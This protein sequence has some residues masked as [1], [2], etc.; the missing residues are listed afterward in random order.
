VV[1]IT[2]TKNEH[3]LSSV[4]MAHFV[5]HGSLR[6]DAVVPEGM[7]AEGMAVLAAGVPPVP[8][9]TPV[10]E[11]YPE[12]SFVRRLIDLPE[13]AGALRSLVGPGPDVDHHAVHVRQP[14]EGGA[15]PLHGDAIIATR[16][17]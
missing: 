11:A 16:R 9:G 17:R 7:N 5:A 1:R 12:G 13:V 10:T 4:R 6:L 2:S 15:Q 3:L 14:R 8:Y